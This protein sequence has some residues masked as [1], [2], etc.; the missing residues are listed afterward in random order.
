MGQRACREP[1][2]NAAHARAHICPASDG[3]SYT[4]SGAAGCVI[5]SRMPYLVTARN[6]RLSSSHVKA[7]AASKPDLGEGEPLQPVVAHRLRDLRRFRRI[8]APFALKE[9]HAWRTAAAGRPCSLVG[10]DGP[11]RSELAHQDITE[12]DE[13][14]GRSLQ[15]G[16]D[17]AL[18]DRV[19]GNVA[20]VGHAGD[21]DQVGGVGMA[22]VLEQQ[23]KLQRVCVADFDAGK[24]HASEC[25]PGR[26]GIATRRDFRQAI[27][28]RGQ[29]RAR[30]VGNPTAIAQRTRRA[31][32][33]QP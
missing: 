24:S 25:A 19:E 29:V 7:A 15:Y 6:V 21:S 8:P 23:R 10:P 9:G 17:R 3:R 31:G 14:S 1:P 4:G 12:V 22:V 28:T 27:R 2:K 26:F 11:H 16:D 30:R 32:S 20:V 18:V 33:S 13:V 5:H